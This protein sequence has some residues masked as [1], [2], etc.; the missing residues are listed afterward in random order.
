VPLIAGDATGAIAPVPVRVAGKRIFTVTELERFLQRRESA[1]DSEL[2]ANDVACQ[3]GAEDGSDRN[4]WARSRD[5]IDRPR[6][7]MEIVQ[8]RILRGVLERWDFRQAGG[9]RELLSQELETGWT[10]EAG[11][12]PASRL[13]VMLAR[14]AESETRRRLAA[15]QQCHREVE[16]LVDWPDA[17]GVGLRGVIDCLWH[18]KRSGWHV[19]AFATGRGC[20]QPDDE[21]WGDRRVGLVLSA[22]AAERHLGVRPNS[23]GLYCF[24]TGTIRTCAGRRLGQ[25]RVLAAAGKALRD[26]ARQLL[27]E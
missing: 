5:E 12:V 8:D 17:G 26:C 2:T 16:F 18:E 24:E 11:A 14:F 13:E 3:F 1:S 22:W 15:A 19:L 7:P 4:V 27:R 6:V 25:R 20:A 21:T 10:D 23:V 9:W